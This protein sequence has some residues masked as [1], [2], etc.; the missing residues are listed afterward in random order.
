MTDRVEALRALL[1]KY[2]ES[3]KRLED[4]STLLA[5]FKPS[6]AAKLA[7]E[8]VTEQIISDLKALIAEQEGEGA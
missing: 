8:A 5:N 6:L 1:S 3:Y 4:T 7:S 2:E